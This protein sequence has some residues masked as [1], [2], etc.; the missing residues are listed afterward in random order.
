MG[1]QTSRWPVFRSIEATARLRS[2]TR[3]LLRS[4]KTGNVG[5]VAR[6]LT[7]SDGAFFFDDSTGQPAWLFIQTKGYARQVVRFE[8]RERFAADEHGL[9][10]IPLEPGA[11]VSGVYTRNGAPQFHKQ[12]WL[13][14]LP[15]NSRIGQKMEPCHADALGRFEWESLPAGRYRITAR[16]EVGWQALPVLT[17]EFTLNSGES[18]TVNL[19]LDAPG[20]SALFGRVVDSEGAPV[21]NARVALKPEFPSDRVFI[22]DYT[23]AEGQYRIEGLAPGNY[24]V[25]LTQMG[26]GGEGEPTHIS[27]TLAGPMER[28]FVIETR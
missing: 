23:N 1:G 13:E 5:D 7:G 21:A 4:Y 25:E 9:L 6:V 15:G 12:V 18:K 22:A 27:L 26:R 11:T 2:S 16:R 24:G 17:K 14:L 10:R 3:R 19:A 20:Q 28:D 8:D